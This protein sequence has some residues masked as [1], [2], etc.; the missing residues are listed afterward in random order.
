MSDLNKKET[1]LL[2]E[3]KTAVQ[4]TYQMDS[5]RNKITSFFISIAGISIAGFLLVIKGKDESINISNLNEIVSIIMLIVAILGHLFICV[6]AKIR[7]VQLEHFAIINNIRKYFIELDYTMWNIVQ[8]SDKTLP[9]ARLFSGTYWWQFVIQV[10]NGFILYLGILL[11]FDL[12]EDIITWKSFFIFC[13]TFIFSIL[14]QNLFY[15]KIANG[16]L[17]VT[18][19][20][21]S[22]PY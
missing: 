13:G 12:L 10:I 11:L 22:K 5:L 7:K 4:L 18:Y 2:E 20:E 3:Y 17:K 21:N 15:F 19:S 9:K 8:L 6:L 16:Y 14:L 1:F